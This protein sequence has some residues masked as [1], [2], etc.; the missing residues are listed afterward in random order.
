MFTTP[1]SSPTIVD[2]QKPVW[3]RRL[4]W[5][6]WNI[7]Q[8]ARYIITDF[9]DANGHQDPANGIN[10]ASGGD[11]FFGG[12]GFSANGTF[13]VTEEHHLVPGRSSRRGRNHHH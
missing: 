4:A 13:T 8:P 3:F 2:G 12:D 5:L 1:T 10:A 9:G 6:D 11:T 7:Y